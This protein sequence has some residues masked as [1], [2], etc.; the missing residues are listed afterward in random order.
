MRAS[1][2]KSELIQNHRIQDEYFCKLIRRKKRWNYSICEF[3]RHGVKY[4]IHVLIVVGT[5]V[6]GRK[7]NQANVTLVKF[8]R[9]RVTV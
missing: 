5:D 2:I 6:L 4:A 8:I 3:L 1:A 7:D 9:V